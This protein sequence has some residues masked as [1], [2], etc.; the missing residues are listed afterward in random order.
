MTA[1]QVIARLTAALREVQGMTLYMQAAQDITI[2]ARLSKTQYQFTLVDIN[3][4]ELNYYAPKLVAKLKDLPELTA[5]AS[6]QEA[7]GRTLKVQI[8]RAAAALFGITPATIDS[9]LYDAFG[10]RHVARI[11][12]ALNEYYVIL[13]VNQQYQLGPNAL[14]RIY[15]LSQ[16]N[17]MTP[18]KPDRQPDA[19]GN[20]GRHQSSG[21]VSVGHP[22]LQSGAGRDDRRGRFS[23]AKGCRRS[24][25]AAI[26]RH[27][28]PGQ[29]AGLPKL[30]QHHA[31]SD[32]CSVV[33]GLH[34]PRRAL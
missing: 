9:T 21:A 20:P 26:D 17:T 27:G 14:Q 24:S 2:G 15:V 18:L 10:Q 23:G 16:N 19:G 7:P 5:V 34:H 33:R 6:D 25:P 13:E 22:Q 28:F 31:P 32:P 1:D 8:D 30:A 4:D 11:Y 29:R 12:T 3:Q